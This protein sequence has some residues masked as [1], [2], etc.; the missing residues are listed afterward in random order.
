MSTCWLAAAQLQCKALRLA[1]EPPAPIAEAEVRTG[2]ANASVTLTAS[3]S[4]MG[5]RPYADAAVDLKSTGAPLPFPTRRCARAVLG[6]RTINPYVPS[7]VLDH[8]VTI[9]CSPSQTSAHQK[10]HRKMGDP[11]WFC[12]QLS[13]TKEG[14]VQLGTQVLALTGAI[15]VGA[16]SVSGP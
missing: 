4:T 1:M 16:L 5:R 2:T 11:S 7:P 12:A 9:L 8:S 14:C 10:E 6:V 13:L 15:K 3:S